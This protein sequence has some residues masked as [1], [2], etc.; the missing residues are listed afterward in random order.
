[1]GFAE[2]AAVG[3]VDEEEATAAMG[4][5]SFRGRRES[6]LEEVDVGVEGP[7]SEDGEKE[8]AE[9][10]EMGAGVA[11]AAELEAAARAAA[12]GG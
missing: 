10:G 8:E 6:E 11:A 2:T 3:V 9:L 7:L 1:V 12:A 4:G 5:G